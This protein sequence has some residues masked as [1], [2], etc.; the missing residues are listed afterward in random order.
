MKDL[1]LL[2]G[3]TIDDNYPLPIDKATKAE[4]RRLKAVH[5]FDVN[6]W[7]RCYIRTELPKIKK[8]LGETA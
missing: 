4:M 7:L 1:P 3:K 2:K 8:R 5:R 6:A